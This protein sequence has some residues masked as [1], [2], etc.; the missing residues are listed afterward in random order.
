MPYCSTL[1]LYGTSYAPGSTQSFYYYSCRAQSAPAVIAFQT[2]FDSTTTSSAATATTTQ[3]SSA[4]TSTTSSSASSSVSSVQTPSTNSLQSTQVSSVALPSTKAEIISSSPNI[5]SS[6]I[7]A[8]STTSASH[9]TSNGLSQTSQIGI[10]VGV[11]I[12]VCILLAA[13]AFWFFRSRKAKADNRWL[14][15]PSQTFP[16]YLHHLDGNKAVQPFDYRSNSFRTN[17]SGKSAR[18]GDAP[19]E[20]SSTVKTHELPAGNH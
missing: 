1:L 4:S 8:P 2:T 9:A 3:T 7:A 10:A 15:Q 6:T 14:N 5:A 20:L 17:L 16:T 11:S 12:G 13:V 19:Y 18:E